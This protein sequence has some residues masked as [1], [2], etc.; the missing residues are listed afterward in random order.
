MLTAS[1]NR[2]CLN[3][4]FWYVINIYDTLEQ[5]TAHKNNK[6]QNV[7]FGIRLFL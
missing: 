3:D 7:D 1:F 6:N 4:C 5:K 2:R